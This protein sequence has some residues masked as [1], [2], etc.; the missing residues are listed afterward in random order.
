MAAGCCRLPGQEVGFLFQPRITRITRNAG[1]GKCGKWMERSKH[2]QQGRY[3][4]YR[5]RMQRG[6]SVCLVRVIRVIRGLP[7]VFKDLGGKS[8]RGRDLPIG[9][10]CLGLWLALAWLPPAAGG[11]AGGSVPQSEREIPVVR[12]ADVLVVGGTLV[13][14]QPPSK[15]RRGGHASAWPPRGPILA[16]TSPRCSASGTTSLRVAN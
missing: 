12:Q 4:E 14:W 10:V 16:R 9:D 1:S 13:R 7:G 15:R 2:G 3:M 5:E 6:S 11:A 8:M